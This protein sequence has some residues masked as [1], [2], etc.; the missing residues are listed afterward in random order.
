MMATTV[1]V[2]G[3]TKKFG[4]TDAVGPVSL[5]VEAG[6]FFS[7]LGPSGCGK[8][9][10]LR[11]I[12]GFEDP[13]SGVI[14]IGGE[15]VNATPVERRGVGMVFQN[16][17]L[18]P[19]LTVHENI[20]FGLRLRRA[21]QREIEKRVKESLAQVGLDG[22]GD[23]MPQQLSGGQQQRA[24]LARALIVQPSVLLLD[25]P[26]SNLDLKL[27]E[28]MRDEIRRIQK[29][30]GI[31]AVYVTHDQG[32]AMAI[33]DRTAVM[34]MGRIEQIGTPRQI[35]EQP[36][37]LFVAGFIGQCN[38]LSGTVEG[39]QGGLARFNVSNGCTLFVST[40]S[41]DDATLR[42]SDLTLVVRPEAVSIR[43]CR[44]PAPERHNRDNLIAARVE[45]IV[46]LGEKAELTIA[47]LAE[48]DEPGHRIVASRNTIRGQEL[49]RIGDVVTICIPPEECIL[50]AGRRCDVR[51]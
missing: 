36:E 16:Y 31:T 35:Y 8:T 50:V 2:E 23:R 26:L 32:E 14:R 17:A 25:E 34:N 18:F 3:V 51:S 20:A 24:A 49:P 28:Q 37:T 10:T 11:L 42:A 39:A 45:E 19:H 41:V 40:A 7:L 6:E 21:G 30:L 44:Q 4:D 15:V 47:L 1:E 5:R 38:F 22:Y 13:T 12:A 46:Y 48:A 33:S 9:T 27:R 43:S 29:S